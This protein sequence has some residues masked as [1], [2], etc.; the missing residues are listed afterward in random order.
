LCPPKFRFLRLLVDFVLFSYT[1]PA[2]RG[3]AF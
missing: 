1:W 2:K 3:Q